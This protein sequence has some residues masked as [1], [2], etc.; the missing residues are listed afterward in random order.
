MPTAWSLLLWSGSAH[1]ELELAVAVRECPLGFGAP[2]GA[3]RCDLDVAVEVH[4]GLGFRACCRGPVVPTAMWR[5]L[6]G[7]GVTGGE[8]RLIQP[9]TSVAY[10]ARLVEQI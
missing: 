6:G 7:P 2:V 8:K 4:R 1:C 5:L 9:Y 3:A 10:T